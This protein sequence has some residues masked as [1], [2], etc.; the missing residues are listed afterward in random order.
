[1][2]PEWGFFHSV[3][4]EQIIG[5]L[6]APPLNQSLAIHHLNIVVPIKYPKVIQIYIY[7]DS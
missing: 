3:T 6:F 7:R 4:S 2:A 1:M 5:T